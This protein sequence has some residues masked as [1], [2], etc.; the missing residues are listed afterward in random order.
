MIMPAGDNS[1]LVYQNFLPVLP[2]ETSGA[3]RKN[4]RRNENFAYQYLWYINGSLTCR[5]ILRRGSSDFTSHPK[6]G[7]LRIVIVL[8]N[9]SPRPG[10]N[11]RPLGPLASTLTTT[12]PRR[13]NIIYFVYTNLSLNFLSILKTSLQ[14]EIVIQKLSNTIQMSLRPVTFVWNFLWRFAISL[15]AGLD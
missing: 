5:K 15:Y 7:V 1:W 8:K 13:P 6:E 11:S 3:S 2:A 4:G 12:P 10:L 14:V 9:P